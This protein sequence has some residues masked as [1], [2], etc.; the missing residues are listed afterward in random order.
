MQKQPRYE[1]RRLLD[2]AHTAPCFACFPHQC[3]QH[4]GCVPAH[5]NWLAFGKGVGL[6]AH[7]WAFA[8]MCGPAHDII[9]RR[10]P[11]DMD[12]AMLQQEWMR[13][14]ISTQDHLWANRL[15]RVT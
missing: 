3:T 2:L 11:S 10:V 15:L 12:E 6:K 4:L 7:D 8:A 13:A 14:F 1:N 5:A 9:D